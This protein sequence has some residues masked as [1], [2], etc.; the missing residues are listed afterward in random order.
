MTIETY[1]NFIKIIEC[2]NILS[3][4]SELMIAQPALSTQLKNLE[5][6]LG[7]QLVERGPKRISLTSAGEIFYK[8]ALAICALDTSLHEE[9][10]NYLRGITGTLKISMTPSNPESF[11]HMLFD[12]FVLNHPHVAFQFHEAL[13]PQIAENVKNGICEIGIT[14]SAIRN[15]E[16][17]HMF[18]LQDEEIKAIVSADSALAKYDSLTLDQ[19]RDQQIS[20]TDVIAPRVR[21]AFQSIGCEPNFYLTSASKRTS[22]FWISTYKNCVSMLPCTEDEITNQGFRCKILRITDYDFN[23]K[24][25]IIIMKNRKLSPIAREF[26]K[27]IHM[28]VNFEDV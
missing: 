19:L 13:T 11:L 22:L 9:L 15:A 18:P 24:R 5:K 14:R 27:S 2:G 1:Y 16:D 17:F 28:D 3:A 20:T 25:N 4:S 12:D 21:Q 7:V 10:G 8:K 26:L 6:S 23:V